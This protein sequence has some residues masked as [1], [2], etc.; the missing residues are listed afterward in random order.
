M[1]ELQHGLWLTFL[2]PLIPLTILLRRP[3]D[4]FGVTGKTLDWFRSYLT[5]RCQRIKL[6]DCLS[7]EADLPFGIPQRSVLGPLLFTLHTTPLSSM[8]A[9]LSIPQY[10]YADDSQ[11]CL[12]FSSGDSAAALNGLQSCMASVQSLVLT[13]KLRLNPNKT[14]FLLI[15]NERER[16]K[17]LSK[18]PIELFGVKTNP[19][20]TAQNLGVIFDK[21]FTF[22]SHI[23]AVCSSCFYY[24]RDLQHIRRHLDLDSAKLFATGL[25]SSRLDYSNSLLYG[26]ADVGVTKLQWVQNRLT[27]IVT[28]S[29]LF[30]RSVPL[31]RFLHWL[32]VKFRILFKISLLTFKTIHE[33]QPV[34]LYSMLAASISS[35]S[36]RSNKGISLSVPRVKTNSGARAFHSCALLFGTTCHC[37]SVQPF[38]SLPSRNI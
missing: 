9:G 30:T 16:S 10:L 15:G 17:Y 29:P 1:A 32:P 26:I 6:G 21:N 33:K 12:S 3:D 25:V 13:N 34:Y 22:R 11:L 2:L 24:M 4:W 18:F 27:R 23:S 14:E 37:V 28:K 7:F 20:K 5:G 36:L 35:H 8:I 38:Q 19:A 31:L